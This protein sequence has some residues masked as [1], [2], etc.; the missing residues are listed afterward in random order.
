MKTK[1][2]TPRAFRV[3]IAIPTEKKIK[4]VAGYKKRLLALSTGNHKFDN[5]CGI[6][7]SNDPLPGGSSAPSTVLRENTPEYEEAEKNLEQLYA[8]GQNL[9]KELQSLNSV[10]FSLLWLLKKATTLE[11]QRN[12]QGSHAVAAHIKA[13]GKKIEK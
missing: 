6:T 2:A 1:P 5:S 8:K 3:P 10:R 7:N 9:R 12:H 11:T 13:L 4:T